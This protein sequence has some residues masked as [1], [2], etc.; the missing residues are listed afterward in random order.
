MASS[1]TNPDLEKIP[2]IEIVS[3]EEPGPSGPKKPRSLVH[4]H[5]DVKDGKYKCKYCKQG[6]IWCILALF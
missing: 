3:D 2:V 1:A 4:A 6:H 5:F